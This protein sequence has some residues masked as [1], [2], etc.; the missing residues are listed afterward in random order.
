MLSIQ[1]HPYIDIQFVLLANGSQ[2]KIRH[3][4]CRVR[5]TR[6]HS[7]DDLEC[8]Q[9]VF[10]RFVQLAP[11]AKGMS[12]PVKC[13]SL[14]ERIFRRKIEGE[15]LPVIIQSLFDRTRSLQDV[16]ET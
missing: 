5:R 13:R 11:C 7:L 14:V 9:G 4:Q 2:S 10:Q 16:T 6:T 15:C 1:L 12:H 3:T 8:G